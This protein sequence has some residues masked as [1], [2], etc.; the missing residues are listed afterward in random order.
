MSVPATGFAVFDTAIGRCAV[1]WHD[2]ALVATGLPN[3]DEAATRRWIAERHPQASEGPPPA[4]VQVAVEGM[5]RLLAGEPAT[6]DGVRLDCG[7][8][9]ALERRVWLAAQAI[10]PGVTR[11]YGE[12]ALELGDAGLARSVGQALGRN[13]F[14]LVVPCHRVVAAGGRTGGFS[15]PG[16]VQTKLRLLAIER[17]RPPEPAGQGGLF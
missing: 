17:A 1:V 14:P 5:R 8:A 4:H 2:D 11:T 10:P 3:A 12:I 9:S 7:G 15:A 16:S 13:P 6:F